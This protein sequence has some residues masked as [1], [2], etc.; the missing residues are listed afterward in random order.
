MDYEKYTSNADKYSKY[1]TEYPK[2]FIDY[3]YENIG[4]SNDSI[5]ADIGSGTGKLSGKLLL[6]G[7]QVYSVEPNDDM[8]RVA[9]NDLSRFSKFISINGTAE[10]T[11]LQNSSVDFI[12]IY[13]RSFVGQV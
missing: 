2:E 1:R 4:F 7:S 13:T 3:L 9:Q 6:K 5:I 12:T 8:R 11:T 10:N